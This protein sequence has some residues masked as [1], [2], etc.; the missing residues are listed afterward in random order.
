MINDSITLT[1]KELVDQIKHNFVIGIKAQI[2]AV[3]EGGWEKWNG[4]DMLSKLGNVIYSVNKITQP[5]YASIEKR[6][7]A[8]LN[9]AI[10]L[11]DTQ[12]IQTYLN[13][14]DI[15]MAGKSNNPINFL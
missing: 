15:V 13:V 14:L 1:A 8:K 7:L 3:I 9:N 11:E 6:A 4:T 2:D 5:T 10:E 12:G